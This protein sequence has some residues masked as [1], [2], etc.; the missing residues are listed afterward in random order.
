ME[1]VEP[2]LVSALVL[3]GHMLL[4]AGLA[5]RILFRKLPVGATLAWLIILFVLPVFGPALYL[6]IG[7]NRLGRKRAQRW[8]DIHDLYREWQ[9]RL[10]ARAAVDW[11]LLHPRARSLSRHGESV[12]GF[13]ALQGHALELLELPTPEPRYYKIPPDSFN[14][15]GEDVLLPL[16]HAN[17]LMAGSAVFVPAFGSPTDDLACRRLEDALPGWTIVPVLSDVLCVGLGG[18]HCLTMQQPREHPA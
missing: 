10:N 7:E 5:V 3:G 18:V 11:E 16:S 2:G 17:F 15:T 12:T 14:P 6:F 8:R 9:G 1:E 13:S 4:V